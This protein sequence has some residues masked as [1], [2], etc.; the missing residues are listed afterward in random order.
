MLVDENALAITDD[1]LFDLEETLSFEHDSEN[2]PC[3]DV[4]GIVEF[5]ELSQKRLGGFF[6]NGL[7]RRWRGVVNA[8]PV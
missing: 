2:V 7:V 5:D 8:V 1:L 3:R 6:L 4:L